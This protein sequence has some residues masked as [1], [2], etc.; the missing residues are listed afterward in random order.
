[1]YPSQLKLFA[2]KRILIT[3][4]QGFIG[5]HLVKQ[6]TKLGADVYGTSRSRSG[7]NLYKIDI[8]NFEQ[9]N[10]LMQRKKINCCIHL[11]GES[12]VEAG[13]ENPYQTFSVNIQGT[14]NVLE[15]GRRNKLERLIIA[16]TSHVYGNNN[17]PYH[18]SYPTQPSRPYETS[19]ACTDLIAESYA[20][21]FQLPVLIP[22]FVNIYGPGDLNFSRI[23]PKT[24]RSVIL[25]D[26]P[27]MWGDGTVSRD[28]LYIDD[29][30]DA[31]CL[32]LQADIAAISDNRIFNF[33]TSNVITVRK[34]I[35][36]IIDLSVKKN[37]IIKNAQARR[38][39]EIKSQ[40]VSWG[41][42]KRLFGWEPKVSLEQGLRKSFDWYNS[43]LN[44]K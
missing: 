28:Y 38:M 35:Q 1:M 8:F 36:R 12:V 15:A 32:L 11:A 10:L 30:V 29:A 14:L 20:R 9:L 19:K 26:S 40:Y 16:S 21:T 25:G 42:A 43:Y 31:Y 27:Q 18:E 39:S 13:Q 3:G 5:S 44:F 2:N 6:L 17:L 7:D 24:M 4:S 23:I 33:G 22:R 37:R 41:K 34:L